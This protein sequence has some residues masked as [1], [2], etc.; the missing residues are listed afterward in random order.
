MKKEDYFKEISGKTFSSYNIKIISIFHL[1]MW[2]L[3]AQCQIMKLAQKDRKQ[4]ISRN[5][6]T[7]HK[8]QQIKSIYNF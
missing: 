2:Q 5:T 3:A 6:P 8:N 1:F 4:I 7:Q